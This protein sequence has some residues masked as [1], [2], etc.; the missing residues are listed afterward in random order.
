MPDY[1]IEAVK[2]SPYMSIVEGRR[3]RQK[4]RPWML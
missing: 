3:P 1:K 4:S 2:A